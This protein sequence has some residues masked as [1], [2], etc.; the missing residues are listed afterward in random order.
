MFIIVIGKYVSDFYMGNPFYD[1]QS[2]WHYVAYTIFS[3]LMYRYLNHRKIASSKIILYTYILAMIISTAD[4]FFQLNMTNRV[5]DP[6]DIAKDI[7]GAVIGLILIYFVIEKGKIIQT[8]WNLRQNKISGYFKNPSSLLLL[9]LVLTIIFLSF[10]SIL[11]EKMVR[12]NAIF[13]STAVFVII[14]IFFHF[15]KY[16]AVKIILTFLV[17]CQLVSFGIFCR[18]NIIYNSPQLTIYKG[19]PILYFDIMF[20]ENG[21]FRLVD[22]KTYFQLPDLIRLKSYSNDILLLSSGETGK[23]GGGLSKKEKMQFIVNEVKQKPLQ[24]LIL[25][26]KEAVLIYNKLKEQNKRVVFVLHHE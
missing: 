26:N 10:S 2:N 21:F 4:E 12:L 3:Y 24:V 13:I 15:F 16:K 14:F 22:K 9:E 17:I 11:T 23:G 7:L 25:K 20:F 19:I 5:F 6:G 18:K 1:I 8:G